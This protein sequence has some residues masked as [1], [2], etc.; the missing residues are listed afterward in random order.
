[1]K[2]VL[3]HF[4]ACLLARRLF[5]KVS[6]MSLIKLSTRSKTKRRSVWTTPMKR[7]TNRSIWCYVRDLDN[8]EEATI[9]Y[10]SKPVLKVDIKLNVELISIASESRSEF[11]SRARMRNR[12]KNGKARFRWSGESVRIVHCLCAACTRTSCCSRW[13]KHSRKKSRNTKRT[14]KLAKRSADFI[15]TVRW[16]RSRWTDKDGRTNKPKNE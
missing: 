11:W 6:S 1:M 2:R 14:T 4:L 5:R 10:N 7:T 15:R 12:W 9:L 16:S 3:L 8:D 13:C